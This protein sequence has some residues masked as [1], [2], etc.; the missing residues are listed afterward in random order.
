MFTKENTHPST[1]QYSKSEID[2]LN[3]KLQN[4]MTCNISDKSLTTQLRIEKA[5]KAIS[6]ISE[7]TAEEARYKMIHLIDLVYRTK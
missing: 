4:S 1:L 2:M 5:R 7:K 6:G 3:K